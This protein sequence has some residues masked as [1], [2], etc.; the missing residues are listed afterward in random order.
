YAVFKNGGEDLISCNN[1]TKNHVSYCC[2]HAI[3][4]CCDSGDG[5]FDVLPYPTSLVATWNSA[6]SEFKVLPGASTT[7]SSSSSTVS[8]STMSPTTTMAS[9]I[10][11]SASTTPATSSSTVPDSSKNGPGLNK[12]AQIG[13]GLG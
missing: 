8:I 11:S 9:L 4:N 10:T 13:I 2:D 5:R 1:V 6:A 12:G 7:T 3:A